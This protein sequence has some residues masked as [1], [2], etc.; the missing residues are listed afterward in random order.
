MTGN[1][2]DVA[3]LLGSRICHDLISPLGAISNGVELLAMAGEDLGPEMALIS[4]S[5]DNANARI[6][7]FRLAYGA[8]SAEQMSGASEIRSILAAVTRGTRL[9]I[10]WLP[11]GNQP[12]SEAKLAFLLL[13]CFE[14]AMP[15]GGQID[16]GCENGRWTVTGQ[17][18]RM[19]INAR[20]WEVLSRPDL[21]PEIG[22]AEVQFLMVPLLLREA[23]RTL[24]LD[25]SETRV[26]ARF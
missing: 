17:A 12:R 3:A 9:R 23:G 20:L 7:Y 22:A 2:H 18:D 4:E 25:L 10:D 6:R 26:T 1:S 11:D 14:T 16:V 19:K 24:M 21:Q 8:A 5:I 15:W 13:Q